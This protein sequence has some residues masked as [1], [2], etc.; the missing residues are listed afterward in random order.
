MLQ[1]F[2]NHLTH[3]KRYSPHTLK[4]YK[5]DLE[6]YVLYLNHTYDAL[7]PNAALHI[8]IRSWM[9][10]LV[11]AG[12][13]PRS[14]NRKLSTLRSFYNYLLK[15]EIITI[16]PCLKVI[17][18]KSPKKLPSI[19][20]EKNISALFDPEKAIF[21]NTYSGNRNAL[22]LEL[23]YSSGMRRS[24]LINLKYSNIDSSNQWLKVLGKGNKERILPLSGQLIAKL[25]E[26]EIMK[27]EQFQELEG[28]VAPYLFLTDKG[29]QLYPKFVYNLVTRYLKQ[30]STSSKRSPH[31]LRHSFAT[32][33]MNNG[34]DLNAIKEL[35]G[36]SSLAATQVYTH[37]SIQVLKNV[38]KKA[39]PK[40]E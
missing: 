32:H 28:S 19:I 14:I 9:A 38:Y 1:A 21:P 23:F 11:H 5:R 6:Q 29:K 18:P 33:M 39:H 37:N 4:S 10:S 2:F 35:L 34:A 26:F 8:H 17:S 12:I 3:E 40:A 16:N 25:M 31:I 13:S 24:E 15:H 27:L 7:S 20:Q 22:I 30:V 36:H